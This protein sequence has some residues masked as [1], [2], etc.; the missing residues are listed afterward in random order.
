MQATMRS[1]VAMRVLRQTPGAT[2]RLFCFPYAGAGPSIFN[3]WRGMLP[4]SVDLIGVVYPGRECRA[5]EMPA[6]CLSELVGDLASQLQDFDE[7]PC[8]FFGHSMGAYVSFELARRLAQDAMRPQHLFLSAAGAPHLPEPNQIHQLPG[9]E[10]L[11][12]LLR[13]N[14]F[15][16]E[17][18]R[19]S[20]LVKYALPILRADFTVCETYRF[21]ADAP[22]RC[23][24]TVYGGTNDIRVDR[25]R[26]E[27]WR[28]L[29]S[30]SFSM[31]LFEGDHFYL[32][33]RKAEL[34]S[35]MRQELT[36]LG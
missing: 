19:E 36:R 12:A 18:L 17:V 33:E 13:L 20:E 16:A 7:M 14:G 25:Q 24:M 6:R 27:A 3:D 21:N 32:R 9:R 2:I 15:P 35:S 5:G 26:L 31:K 30:V 1:S 29:A 22:S 34:L 10:F 28:H 23:P 8:A 4:E 11:R